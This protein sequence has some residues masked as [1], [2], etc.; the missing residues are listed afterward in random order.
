[1]DTLAD[2]LGIPLIPYFKGGM[3]WY[4]WWTRNAGETT[5]S[6]GTP[7]WQICPG[8][9]LRLDQFDKMSARTFDN[10][11]GVNHSFIFFELLIANVNG[12]G[13]GDNMYLSP[14]NLWSYA[15]WQAG[16]GIEF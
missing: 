2:E 4:V 1:V 7:G 8:L 5:D 3:N 14:E 16:L 15:T 10:E 6:G 12:F 11:I 13:S 9:A